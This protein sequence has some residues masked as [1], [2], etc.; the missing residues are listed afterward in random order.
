MH[1]RYRTQ[2]SNLAPHRDWWATVATIVVMVVFAYFLFRFAVQD[3]LPRESFTIAYGVAA[4]SIAGLLLFR[5]GPRLTLS[6]FYL[7]VFYLLLRFGMQESRPDLALTSLF[8]YFV[9]LTFFVMGY[10]L[11]RRG[12]FNIVMTA[13]LV[14]TWI[15]LLIGQGNYY[16][17]IAERYFQEFNLEV[18]GAGNEI[19]NRAYSLAGYSL[20]TG[21]LAMTG[22]IL[23]IQRPRW[24]KVLLLPLLVLTLLNSFSRGALVM[25]LVGIGIW[26]LLGIR[27]SQRVG[28]PDHASEKV[29]GQSRDTSS[30]IASNNCSSFARSQFS[31]PPSRSHLLRG[32]LVIGAILVFL[33]IIVIALSVVSQQSF[34]A[35]SS[36]F[37]FDLLDSDEEGNALRF[38]AW[39]YAIR[40]WQRNPLLGA[41]FGTLGSSVAIQDSSAL[42]PE[43]MYFKLLGELGVIGLLLYLL[44]VFTSLVR[45][46]KRFFQQR[47]GYLDS[48]AKVNV[49]LV[50]AILAGGLFLQNLESDFLAALFWFVLGGTGAFSDGFKGGERSEV[51][52]PT[53]IN[54]RIS[55]RVGRREGG[56]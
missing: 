55:K 9:P 25:L 28:T 42:A 38:V 45:A 1:S 21:F 35:Y 52:W 17:G 12:N 50:G 41:G 11:W 8:Q 6:P 49:A 30:H 31:S 14:C 22:I 18:V 39:Q 40:I 23:S 48:T 37:V 53:L 5:I 29:L 15:S 51:R 7:Y 36:R 16:F 43:S 4:I 2:P 44:T 10:Y 34:D 26:A 46:A 13:F 54:N 20:G 24:Q 32:L 33:I 3:I 47:D 56:G 19:V 27:G